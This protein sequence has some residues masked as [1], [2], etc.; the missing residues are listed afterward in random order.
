MQT[1]T[2]IAIAGIIL[3]F[4]AIFCMASQN[5]EQDNR[6]TALSPCGTHQTPALARA[7]K[8]EVKRAN[9]E[10]REHALARFAQQTADAQQ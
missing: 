7:C 10:Y 2:K 9:D 6:A 3:I 8:L 4:V 5:S 1:K